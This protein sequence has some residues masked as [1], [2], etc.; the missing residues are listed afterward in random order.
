MPVYKSVAYLDQAGFAV[1]YGRTNLKDGTKVYGINTRLK[2]AE[3]APYFVC[4]QPRLIRLMWE[5]N[6]AAMLVPFD[7][8]RYHDDEILMEIVY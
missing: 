3:P 8:V 2:D 6:T 7:P 1:G 4:R 5:S